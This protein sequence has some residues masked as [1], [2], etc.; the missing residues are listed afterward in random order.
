MDGHMIYA[1]VS[2]AVGCGEGGARGVCVRELAP[3]CL[4]ASLSNH[5]LRMHTDTRTHTC[6]CARRVAHSET[7]KQAANLCNRLIKN[8]LTLSRGEQLCF[9]ILYYHLLLGTLFV[10]VEIERKL[11]ENCTLVKGNVF[12]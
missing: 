1:N 10:V 6:V 5:F 8:S 2:T 11:N 3:L 4:R 12:N 7:Q 9:K